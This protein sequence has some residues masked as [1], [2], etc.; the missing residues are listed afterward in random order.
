M[1][2]Q[3]RKQRPTSKKQEEST[4]QETKEDDKPATGEQLKQ[5][6]DDILDEIDEVL[7]TSKEFVEQFIQK[8]GEVRG[9]LLSNLAKL[10][11]RTKP[12]GKF[13]ALSIQIIGML[14]LHM[15]DF[16]VRPKDLVMT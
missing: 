9:V 5:D 14:V 8:G 7:E 10:R 2:T 3:E 4:P 15:E 6:I 11:W 13:I 16:P 12:I 1:A